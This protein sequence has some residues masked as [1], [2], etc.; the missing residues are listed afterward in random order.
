VNTANSIESWIKNLSNE[1]SF[2]E[3]I[4]SSSL[5]LLGRDEDKTIDSLRK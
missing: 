5:E 1:H 4:L 3:L 2:K